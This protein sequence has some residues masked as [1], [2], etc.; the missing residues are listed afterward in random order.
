MQTYLL[1]GAM[2]WMLWAC[3]CLFISNEKHKF[4]LS[5]FFFAIIFA[6]GITLNAKYKP[7]EVEVLVESF[8]IVSLQ[9]TQW[10]DIG[11]W[12]FLFVNIS[13]EWFQRYYYATYKSWYYTVDYISWIWDSVRIYQKDEN[14]RIERRCKKEW[15]RTYL[16]YCHHKVI[17]PEWTVKQWYSID[18][19]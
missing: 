4:R 1:I 13:S 14:P 3:L 5:L 17:V 12:W 15:D 19:N 8:N 2:V 7:E 18:L 11:W 9:D 10:T 6:C 16:G